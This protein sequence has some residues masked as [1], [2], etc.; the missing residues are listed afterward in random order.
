MSSIFLNTSGITLPLKNSP[1]S[2]PK[3]VIVTPSRIPATATKTSDTETRIQEISERKSTK[4]PRAYCKKCN[5][6][7]SDTLLGFQIHF[8]KIHKECNKS[9]RDKSLKLIY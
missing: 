2:K 1:T 4:Y 3:Q 7:V 5:K 6:F 9:E 8:G